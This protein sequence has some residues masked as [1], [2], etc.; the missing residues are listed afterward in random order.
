MQ[1][2]TVGGESEKYWYV[3]FKFLPNFNQ[4][5]TGIIFV[6]ISITNHLKDPI[7]R[8]FIINGRY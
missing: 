3:K 5:T 6:E 4:K 8:Y 2:Q 1:G 7:L